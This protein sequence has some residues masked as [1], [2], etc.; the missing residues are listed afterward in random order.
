M[1]GDF[2]QRMARARKALRPLRQGKAITPI[3]LMPEEFE[4]L[5]REGNAFL[6]S[7]IREGVLLFPDEKL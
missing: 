2:Y 3:V 4:K 5:L 6:Q 7:V 1:E